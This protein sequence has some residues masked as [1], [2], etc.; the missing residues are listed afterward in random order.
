M[1]G[2]LLTLCLATL[3]TGCVPPAEVNNSPDAW[4]ESANWPEASFKGLQPRELTGLLTE[5][6]EGLG[7]SLVTETFRGSIEST[8]AVTPANDYHAAFI[9]GRDLPVKTI[10][11]FNYTTLPGRI[12]VTVKSKKVGFGTLMAGKPTDAA[13]LEA[14]EVL[15]SLQEDLK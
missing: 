13:A 10:L 3:L 8:E 7:Y 11:V 4:A 5:K 2:V 15:A 6:L 14:D 12:K 1:K 9:K